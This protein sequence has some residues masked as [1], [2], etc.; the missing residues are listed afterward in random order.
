M[1]YKQKNVLFCPKSTIYKHVKK[2]KTQ[3]YKCPS[4]NKNLIKKLDPISIW[5]GYTCEKQAYT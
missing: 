3:R 1:N 4:Y 2:N 5:I